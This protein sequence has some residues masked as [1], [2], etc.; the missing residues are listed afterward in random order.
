MKL[1]PRFEIVRTYKDTPNTFI[2]VE[3]LLSDA[4]K[5]F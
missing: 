1:I 2:T 3:K 5:L 4:M